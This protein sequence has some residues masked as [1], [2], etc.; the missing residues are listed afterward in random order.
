MRI[1]LCLAAEGN[2]KRHSQIEDTIL[3]AYADSIASLLGVLQSDALVNC[4]LKFTVWTTF[5]SRM[6]RAKSA[7]SLLELAFFRKNR[8]LATWFIRQP[9][10]DSTSL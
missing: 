8:W 3:H 7:V 1:P 9:P 4:S 2:E 6:K 5:A 10:R